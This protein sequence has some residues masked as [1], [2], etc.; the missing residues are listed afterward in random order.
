MSATQHLI[1][2]LVLGMSLIGVATGSENES[3]EY[4]LIMTN[5]SLNGSI[6]QS[7]DINQSNDSLQNQ[8]QMVLWDGTIKLSDRSQT[9]IIIAGIIMI[10]FMQILI[11]VYLIKRRKQNRMF[12]IKRKV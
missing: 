3:G 7:L 6:I 5:A 1:L 10:L 9:R 11:L 8:N 2:V 4:T 12:L